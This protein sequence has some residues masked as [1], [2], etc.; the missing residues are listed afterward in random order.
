[1]LG[2][3]AATALTV[4]CDR[5][6]E[7]LKERDALTDQRKKLLKEMKGLGLP[8]AGIKALLADA[9]KDQEK[10]Q[11]LREDKELAGALLGHPV[12]TGE[13]QKE[14]GDTFA[15]DTVDVGR[16]RVTD[17]SNLEGEIVETGASLK[18]I[19]A[20]AKSEGFAPK[21]IPEVVKIR[22]DPEAFRE[23]SQLLSTYL[24]AVGVSV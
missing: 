19:L 11:A 2:D 1:M 12:F 3:N 8:V 6:E 22:R 14:V 13:V 10:L 24:T 17:L 21:L 15:D 4:Y 23:T 18:E 16:Q 7:T 9:K 5:Y 20:D